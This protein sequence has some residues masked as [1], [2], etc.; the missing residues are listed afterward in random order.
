MSVRVVTPDTVDRSTVDG[1][2]LLAMVGAEET[3]E[4]LLTW[5]RGHDRCPFCGGTCNVPPYLLTN[6]V[7][8]SGLCERMTSL[9]E[10]GFHLSC[11]I[12]DEDDEDLEDEDLDEEARLP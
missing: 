8:S 2:R 5:V 10:A 12:D 3:I 11:A 9:A 6:G 1:R 4:G 7:G